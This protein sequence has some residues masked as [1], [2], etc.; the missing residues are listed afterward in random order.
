MKTIRFKLTGLLMAID[1]KEDANVIDEAE[2]IL[3]KEVSFIENT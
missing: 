2:H 3:R 1:F